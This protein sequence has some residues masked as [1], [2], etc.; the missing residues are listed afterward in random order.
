LDDEGEAQH[1]DSDDINGYLRE[2]MGEEFSAKDFRTW[3][4]TVLAARAFQALGTGNATPRSVTKAVEEVAR[5]LGNTVA[6][7]RRCYIH[8]EIMNSYLDGSLALEMAREASAKLDSGRGLRAD[9]KRVLAV[10][11]RRLARDNRRA[12]SRAA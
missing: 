3:A 2:I 4:G 1:I 6:V 8:P 7:C 10:L 12:A 5:E 11:R 9:E